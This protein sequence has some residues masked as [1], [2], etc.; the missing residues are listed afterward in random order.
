MSNLKK[1]FFIVLFFVTA[2]AHAQEYPAKPNPPKL[3]NDFTNTLTADQKETLEQKLVD[4]DNKTSTQVAVVIIKSLNGSNVADYATELGRKWGVGGSKNN[5]VILLVAKEDR[6]LNIS[7]GYGLE[8]VLPDVVC[9]QIIDEVIKPNFRG[10]DFYGGI[11]QGTDVIIQATKGEYTAPDNYNNGGSSKGYS[12]LI[13]IILLIFLYFIVTN[14]GG[15]SGGSFMSRRGYR[16]Y[17][18]PIFFPTGGGGWSGGG[19]S[20]GGGFGGFGGG[21][22]GGGGASGD[23]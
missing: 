8:K 4:F 10:N 5:G 1:I 17:N 23:W 16:G 21:S 18:G 15:G 14:S 6:K 3:V 22:F 11:N 20:G 9:Q 13:T 2:L 12:V 19:S 7:P